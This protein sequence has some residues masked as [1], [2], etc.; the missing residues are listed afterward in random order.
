MT[1][2]LYYKSFMITIYNCNGST[3]IESIIKLN[4]DGKALASVINYNNNFT[5]VSYAP[6][7]SVT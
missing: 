1:T 5:I 6:N 7:W 3:I 4:Y 2:A